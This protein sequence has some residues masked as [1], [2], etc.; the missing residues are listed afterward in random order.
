MR[1]K[2]IML[3][4]AALW[5]AASIAFLIIGPPAAFVAALFGGA[6]LLAGSAT[7]LFYLALLCV[8]CHSKLPPMVIPT[9]KRNPPSAKKIG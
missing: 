1:S 8:F 5:I 7:L 2:M 3:A 9:Q 4:T 6:A